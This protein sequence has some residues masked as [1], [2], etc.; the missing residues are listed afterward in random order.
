MGSCTEES[1][2]SV[3][4]TKPSALYILTTAF[5]FLGFKSIQFLNGIVSKTVVSIYLCIS[6]NA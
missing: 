3:V 4:L 2:E 1:E 5:I 6:I